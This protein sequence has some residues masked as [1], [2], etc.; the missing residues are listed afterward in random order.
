VKNVCKTYSENPVSIRSSKEIWG[1]FRTKSSVGID[2]Q[3]CFIKKETNVSVFCLL[4]V[5]SS[6]IVFLP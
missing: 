3:Q 2:K 5:E 6:R 1:I 4:T